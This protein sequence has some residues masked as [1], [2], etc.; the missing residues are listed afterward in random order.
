MSDL[1]PPFVP[2]PEEPRRR[3]FRPIPLRLLAP[4]LI[5]L[6]ALCLGLTAIR[7]AIEG[8]LD[9]AVFSIA[10]AAVLDGADGR[11][12]RYLKGT[13]RFGAE[14]DSLSDFV[15]FGVAPA[16]LLYT[17]ILD[18]LKSLGWIAAIVYAIAA[19]L[20]L[21]RFNVM[22][23]DPSRPEWQKNYFVG[24]AAPA[25]AL[26][27]LL[28]VYLHFIVWP[29]GELA[30]PVVAVYTVFIGLLM[31]SRM[32]TFSGKALGQRIARD[33]VLP[34]FVLFVLFTA[35]LVSFPFHVLALATVAYLVS[36]PLGVAR[37]RARAREEAEKTAVAAPEEAIR[38]G[39]G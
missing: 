6:L 13:S 5:T 32:P 18:E 35:L 28:P 3:R 17:F 25:G 27:V 10:V 11:V 37:H 36:L 24:M 14:L 22:L 1:F 4:N 29:V 9:L 19:A 30:A 31:V 39:E 26:T 15:N 21:A 2:D 33:M 23:D 16:L 12:A 34:L 20:R 8:R 38:D 7:M